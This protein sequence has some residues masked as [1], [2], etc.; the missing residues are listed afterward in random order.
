MFGGSG[1]FLTPNMSDVR[2]PIVVL[3]HGGGMEERYEVS[4]VED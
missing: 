2:N 1:A 4:L 3:L